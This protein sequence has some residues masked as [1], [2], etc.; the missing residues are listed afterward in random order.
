MNTLIIDEIRNNVRLD[1]FVRKRYAKNNPS[2][3]LSHIFQAL[4]KGIIKVNDKK[5]HQNYR[6]Q[7]G[8]RV[9]LPL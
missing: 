5:H 1:S 4:R 8:D 2:M 7:L 6:L 9:S 3:P